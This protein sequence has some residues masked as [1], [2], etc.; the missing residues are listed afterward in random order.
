ML[1]VPLDGDYS[2]WHASFRH[3]A[4]NIS[5]PE[6]E[7]CICGMARW[8]HHADAAALLLQVR[9]ESETPHASRSF[10]FGRM[11]HET[12][13]QQCIVPGTT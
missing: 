10:D 12:S 5:L 11:T 1:R 6:G 9:G 7:P 3:P 8:V 13:Q 2:L 4:G